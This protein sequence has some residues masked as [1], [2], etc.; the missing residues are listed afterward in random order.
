MN[1]TKA[2]NVTSEIKRFFSKELMPLAK[3]LRDEA[4][5][6]FP[7][8]TDPDAQTYYIDRRKTTLSP[9]DF[10]IEVGDSVDDFEQA[11]VELWKSQEYS[12][13]TVLASTLSKLARSLRFVEVE[14]EQEGE[15]DPFIYVMF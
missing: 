12:Q 13:L 5:S 6:F 4:I 7:L 10:E 3:T 8:G 14:G 2:S 11:L 9:R 15:V 1:S